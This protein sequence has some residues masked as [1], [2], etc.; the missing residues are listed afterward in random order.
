M[1]PLVTFV[2]ARRYRRE[3]KFGDAPLLSFQIFFAPHQER[4]ELFFKRL[5]L[6]ERFVSFVPKIQDHASVLE[7]RPAGPADLFSPLRC[8]VGKTGGQSFRRRGLSNPWCIV[9]NWP[10][11]ENTM[12]LLKVHVW[13]CISK[14]VFTFILSVLPMLFLFP[15]QGLF[16][17]YTTCTIFLLPSFFCRILTIWT[18]T[19]RWRQPFSTLPK[20]R[21]QS[22]GPVL[23]V[24]TSS[25]TSAQSSKSTPASWSFFRSARPTWHHEAPHRLTALFDR[26]AE[27]TRPGASERAVVLCQT[28]QEI[29]DSSSDG[30]LQPVRFPCA[31]RQ[32]ELHRPKR[33]LLRTASHSQQKAHRYI[34]QRSNFSRPNRLIST[35]HRK[36]S[37]TMVFQITEGS[38]LKQMCKNEQ[39]A[40][41][42]KRNFMITFPVDE[43]CLN[44][45]YLAIDA[46]YTWIY[47]LSSNT[48]TLVTASVLST[49]WYAL[50]VF[51]LR[52][53]SRARAM[54][55][56]ACLYVY[57][58]GCVFRSFKCIYFPVLRTRCN[59]H[60]TFVPNSDIHCIFFARSNLFGSPPCTYCPFRVLISIP[61]RF[62][63]VF[64]V[65][66]HASFS[67]NSFLVLWNWRFTWM[68][69]CL[70]W[71][72]RCHG[73]VQI[74]YGPCAKTS[75][76]TRNRH[77]AESLWG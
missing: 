41:S 50:G 38:L 53:W 13:Q 46:Y 7:W 23:E 34:F 25:A 63:Q 14:L 74:A 24:E 65:L 30:I 28:C 10:F 67:V 48:M 40:P 76:F 54:C 58:C 20:I 3:L 6:T 11:F 64:S 55:E 69:A 2:L 43:R 71:L 57:E 44:Y 18:L 75:Q 60:Y 9:L 56:L 15:K 29:V 17:A 47:C 33:L 68:H 26:S 52:P 45:H 12:V 73:N 22:A 72:S 5:A 39:I 36:A 16:K 21:T 8:N 66:L 31:R 59:S 42:R 37:L 62:F 51:H 35:I 49:C 1:V 27:T 19:L 32:T 61:L 4:L 70:T 77:P